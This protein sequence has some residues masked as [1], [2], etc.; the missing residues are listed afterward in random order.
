MPTCRPDTAMP[1][2]PRHP[3]ASSPGRRHP[4]FLFPGI[5][6]ALATV[7]FA[8]LSFNFPAAAQTGQVVNNGTMRTTFGDGSDNLDLQN[9]GTITVYGNGMEAGADSWLG[10]AG[11]IT[12]NGQNAFG[13]T[14]KSG[15]YL[16]N[17]TSGAIA[18]NQRGGRGMA[19]SGNTGHIINN[20]ASDLNG[21][22]AAG[23]YASD[24]GD[25]VKSVSLTNN[26]TIHGAS[27]SNVGMA[28][29]GDHIT[30]A[31]TA[32]GL[33]RMDGPYNGGM[34]ANGTGAAVVNAGRIEIGGQGGKG[35]TAFGT[36]TTLANHGNITVSGNGGEAIEAGSGVRVTQTGE[37]LVTGRD[38]TGIWLE[39][40]AAASNAGTVTTTQDGSHAIY[41]SGNGIA[42]TN[43]DTISTGGDN[44]IGIYLSGEN[45][46]IDNRGNITTAGE[47]AFGI[48]AQEDGAVIANSGTVLASGNNSAAVYL[49]GNGSAIT[50]SGTI[51]TTGTGSQGIAANGDGVRVEV[52]ENGRIDT[53]A[54]NSTGISA[55]GSGANIIHA[56]HI[57]TGGANS[58]GISASGENAVIGNSGQIVTTGDAANGIHAGGAGASIANNGT[59][60]TQGAQGAGIVTGNDA[61]VTNNGRIVTGRG[62]AVIIGSG[63]S[64]ANN[65]SLAAA[66]R[67]GVYAPGANSAIINHGAI[68]TEGGRGDAIVISGNASSVINRGLIKT[69]G[70]SA[71]GI[72]IAGNSSTVSNTGLILTSGQAAHGMAIT[73]QNLAVSNTGRVW[74]TGPGSHELMVGNTT[75]TASGSASVSVWT[76]ALSPNRWNDPA[77]RPFGVGPGSTLTFDR[78]R[79]VLRPGSAD[80]GFEFGKRYHVADMIDNR[81]TVAGALGSDTPDAIISG[82]MPMLKAKLYNGSAPGALD[83]QVSLSLKEEDNHGQ[84]ANSGTVHRSA[85]RLWLLNRTL[86]DSLDALVASPDWAFF[87]QPYYQH[88]RTTGD[89]SSRADSEG[90]LLGATRLAGND[91]RLGW[92]AGLEHT[93]FSARGHGLRSD[94]SAWLAGLHGRYFLRPGWTLSGQLTATA[95]RSDYDFVMEGDAASDKRTEYGYFAS[96]KSAWDFYLAQDHRLSPEIGLAYLRMRNPSMQAR[97]KQACNQDMN[98]HFERRDFSAVYATAGL[99]WTGEFENGDTAIRPTVAAGVRQNLADGN[100]DSGFTFMGQRYTAHLTEDRTTGTVDAGVRFTRGNTSGAIRYNGEF[101]SHFTD[102]IVW[103][104]M[105]ITF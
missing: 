20:G 64:L 11:T 73:G 1:A 15:S 9:N 38:G 82:L 53:L 103:A 89:A 56:G 54:A 34:V 21:S 85:A 65:G 52:T 2:S 57:A 3:F 102:H 79:F 72:A 66:T 47:A 51:R 81:G 104:E 78:T 33:I 93:G 30:L 50:Q 8:I 14:G 22:S 92:H 59:I 71:S 91:L 7:L 49:D 17:D 16:T 31:N 12:V 69:S 24:T 6:T 43:T 99:R 55:G 44:A 63:S 60:D 48:L 70:A 28:A 96:L 37:V 32:S 25:A 90:V 27:L 98:L 19:V 5:R 94:A 76:L 58:H 100:V 45:N 88:S 61:S 29:E 41:G 68:E 77:S 40:G 62:H 10:N 26:G 86:G 36:G 13:M 18:I 80:S 97:W 84:G 39:S 67:Y 87:I 101:G 95:S 42:V 75:G 46:R 83:Q 74:T 4:V 105:G 23:M 35:M